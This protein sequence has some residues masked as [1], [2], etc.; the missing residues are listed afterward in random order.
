MTPSLTRLSPVSPT[1]SSHLTPGS[2]D[3]GSET[4]T[5]R[6]RGDVRT[7]DVIRARSTP[8][9]SKCLLGASFPDPCPRS[10]FFSSSLEFAS[11]ANGAPYT[12][13]RD[14]GR[15]SRATAAP[16]DSGLVA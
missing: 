11:D 7:D 10:G 14:R 12:H 13:T 2:L 5:V 8:T 9:P 1:V 6:R 3:P 15:G 4:E 16:Q